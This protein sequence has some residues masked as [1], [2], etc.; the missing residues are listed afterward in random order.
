MAAILEIASGE[1]WQEFI[2]SR[3]LSGSLNNIYFYTERDDIKDSLAYGYALRQGQ[4]S[5]S[6]GRETFEWGTIGAAGVYA[7]AKDLVYLVDE[8]LR[9]SPVPEQQREKMLDPTEEESYGWHVDTDSMGRN[10]VHKGGDSLEYTSQILYYPDSDIT[11]TWMVNNN[12][13]RWRTILRDGLVAWVYDERIP[14]H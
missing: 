4:D 7:R 6:E 5:V 13:N 3:L 14:E 9:Q 1:Q 10:R 8:L 11:I 12:R 2:D